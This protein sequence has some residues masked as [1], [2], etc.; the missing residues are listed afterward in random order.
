MQDIGESRDKRKREDALEECGVFVRPGPRSIAVEPTAAAQPH[1][2]VVVSATGSVP[3]FAS[4][5]VLRAHLMQRNEEQARKRAERDARR[6]TPYQRNHKTGLLEWVLHKKGSIDT[7]T[8]G[9]HSVVA[10]PS[11]SP[12]GE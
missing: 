10:S 1:A 12:W 7:K 9:G 8:E 4:H 11:F 6:P 2:L 3:H 5:G